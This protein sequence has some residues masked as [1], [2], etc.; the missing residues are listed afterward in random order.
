LV[1][2]HIQESFSTSFIRSYA[3]ILLLRLLLRLAPRRTTA[4]LSALRRQ[5]P[6]PPHAHNSML[7]WHHYTPLKLHSQFFSIPSCSGH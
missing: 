3:R 7:Y 6:L 4:A 2:L 1:P 5:P